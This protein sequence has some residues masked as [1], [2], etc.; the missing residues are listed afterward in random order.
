MI[1]IS[2]KSKKNPPHLSEDKCGGKKESSNEA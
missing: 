2:L 1:H